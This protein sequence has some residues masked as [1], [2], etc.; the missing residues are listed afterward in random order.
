MSKKE[1]KRPDAFQKV[2]GDAG[3]WL[4]ER[5]KKVAAGIVVVLVVGFGVGLASY[6]SNR[7]TDR[8][9]KELGDAL[10][11]LSR[12]VDPAASPPASA[13]EPPF[14]SER[15]KDEALVKRL[16]EF[17]GGASGKADSTAA[18]LMGQANLRL[19]KLDEALQSFEAFL[20]T[21]TQDDPLRA[22][23][24]EGKGYALEAKGQLDQ[25]MAAFDQLARENKTEFL[26]GMGLYHRARLLI[27]QGKKEDAAKELAQ[28]PSAAPGSAAA[29]LA[30]DRMALLVAEG[31]KVP[32][33]VAARPDAGTP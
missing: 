13:T 20:K 21:S 8:S 6:A 27:L 1:L 28:I 12:P 15:E 7:G 29:R 22:S 16:T 9:A 17:R 25:A 31:V 24:L 23:A 26:N 2:G 32:P 14:K 33:P 30:S 18:L 10:K 19:G 11:V 3:A 4:V 5:Q